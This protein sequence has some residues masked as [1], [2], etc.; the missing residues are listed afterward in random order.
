MDEAEL[1]PD[2]LEALSSRYTDSARVLL[3]SSGNWAVFDGVG[4]G[5]S[6]RIGSSTEQLT[7]AIAEVQGAAQLEYDRDREGELAWKPGP[8]KAQSTDKTAEEMEL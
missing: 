6:C 3:L 5:H 2:Q 1:S 8:P 7:A 4:S